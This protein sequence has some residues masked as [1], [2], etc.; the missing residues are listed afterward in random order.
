[1]NSL[2]QTHFWKYLRNRSYRKQSN[3]RNRLKHLGDNAGSSTLF[4]PDLV[5]DHAGTFLSLG[6]EIFHRKVYSFASTT[7]TPRVIDCGANIGMASAYIKT[8]YPNAEITAFEA[9]PTLATTAQE[10]MQR[11]GFTLVNI[12]PSAAWIENGT[13]HFAAT[14]GASGQVAAEGRETISIPAV[15]LRDYL[16]EPVTFLKIDIEGSELAVMEDSKDLLRNVNS[17]FVEYHSFI[18]K[19]QECS[20]ILEILEQA[21]MRYVIESNILR[22]QPLINKADWGGIDMAANI[23]AT[24]D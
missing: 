9:D 1:M 12:I 14:G 13:I 19:P 20:R 4:G 21:G 5:F 11:N 18:S 6:E 2:R 24:R 7:D 17:L 23:F 22:N 16:T 10:N 8:R 3:E 15:R